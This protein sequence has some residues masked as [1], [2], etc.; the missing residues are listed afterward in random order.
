MTACTP[1]RIVSAALFDH[2][3]A[4]TPGSERWA[5]I[6]PRA[7]RLSLLLG[8]ARKYFF[9]EKKKQ[10]T[11]ALSVDATGAS[12]AHSKY[13][14]FFWFFFSKKNCFPITSFLWRYV[15]LNAGWCQTIDHDRNAAT[16]ASTKS[17]MLV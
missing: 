10:K 11:F 12:G 3:T 17:R 6:A 9:F 5:A 13:T 4:R 7:A 15:T 14:K 1:I 16:S 8:D 2:A